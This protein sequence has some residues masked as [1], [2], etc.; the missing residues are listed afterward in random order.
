VGV[1][2]G[3]GLQSDGQ[4][5]GLS[6]E[7]GRLEAAYATDNR[8]LQ[9]LLRDVLD[10]AGRPFTLRAAEAISISRPSVKVSWGGRDRDDPPYE[11]LSITN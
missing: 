4:G 8:R 7:G 6:I 1:F 3:P 5:H 10:S 11:G 9:R 2:S